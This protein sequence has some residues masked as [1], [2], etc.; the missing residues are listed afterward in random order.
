MLIPRDPEE[1]RKPDILDTESDPRILR[2]LLRMMVNENDRLHG[3]IAQIEAEKAKTNQAKISF[4]E[5]LSVLR[6]K[7]FGKSSEKSPKDRPRDRN[8]DE[9]ELTVHSQNLLPPPSK[10]KTRD[11]PVEELL[12]KAS[13]DDLALMSASLGLK[14][15][16]AEQWEEIAGLFEVSS[17][18]E[19]TERSFK[20]VLHKRK[21]YRLKSQFALPEKEM[22]IS[23]P[24][25]VKLVP[26]SS[27]SIDFAVATV[28]DKYLNHLPLERQCRM[29][30]SQGLHG[31]QTQ[32]LYNL[33]RLASMHLEPVVERIRS[34][35]LSKAL[36]HSDET[37][38]PI[39]NKKDGYSDF[40]VESRA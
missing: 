23:A 30:A 4:E 9:P 28:T 5:S 7:Y 15:P 13:A 22:I 38:W 24:G 29:M 36:V 27:Y 16:S 25:P 20:T 34:E 40:V 21:K 33:A 39:N 1:P 14:D 11:L 8:S 6:K 31:M 35:I 32:V 10:K 18:I 19:I 2:D 12:H 3:V 37:T 17:E 26:G